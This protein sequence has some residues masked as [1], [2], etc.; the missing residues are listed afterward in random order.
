[1]KRLLTTGLMCAALVACRG[2][3]G[4][5]P[6][7]PGSGVPAAS[8]DATPAPPTA[9]AGEAPPTTPEADAAQAAPEADAAPAPAGDPDAQAP[10]AAEVA[11]AGDAAQGPVAAPELAS[12]LPGAR[13]AAIMEA[14]SGASLSGTA[15]MAETEQGVTV[16]LKLTGAPPGAHAVH[17]HEKGDCSAPD[18][19][20]AGD[21][22]NPRGHAHGLPN[23]DERHLGDFGNMM[24]AED[25]TG[26][27]TLTAP[28]ANLEPGD[29]N[30]FLGKAL[31]VHDKPDTGE[32]PAGNAGPRIA[33]GVL[34]PI[35]GAA[36]PGQPQPDGGAATP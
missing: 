35:Q 20:S 13:V 26:T 15:V 6:A 2:Q 5:Q 34:R 19:T 32:Q 17:V 10:G 33:C 3:E 1:M 16:L 7:H 28:G 24:V 21:H 22:F 31:I 14:R 9:D 4:P 8:E 12:E 11:A 27:L 23:T 36:Q 25:G 18:A 29:T 30:S